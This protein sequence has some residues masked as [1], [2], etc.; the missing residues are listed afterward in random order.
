MSYN[1]VL[2]YFVVDIIPVWAIGSSFSWLL[3]HGHILVGF[4][5]TSLLSGTRRC[6]LYILYIP[7]PNHF[8]KKS[9][10][11]LLR[12]GIRNQDLSTGC[13]QC[14]WVL[15]LLG[16]YSVQNWEIYM[17]ILIVFWVDSWG[18]STYKIMFYFFLFN[19]ETFY[20]FVFFLPNHI[21]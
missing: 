18:F 11:F 17:Y 5:L 4:S 14:T 3:C 2:C 6:S 21:S 10:F 16:P 9:N 7:C 20:V 1:P 15:L 8:S 19:L 12:N 13:A